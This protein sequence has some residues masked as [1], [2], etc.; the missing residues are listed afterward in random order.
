MDVISSGLRPVPINR[1]T[2]PLYCSC[3]IVITPAPLTLSPSV[4]PKVSMKYKYYEHLFMFVKWNEN[5]N[6][7][8]LCCHYLHSYMSYVS[9]FI[10]IY[11]DDEGTP[12]MTIIRKSLYLKGDNISKDEG[13]YPLTIVLLCSWCITF[14]NKD[15]QVPKMICASCWVFVLCIQY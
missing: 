1:W 4:E 2:V 7:L 10:F 9:L 15:Q 5:V 3:C 14:E 12:F 8:S 13:P 11:Q 6:D